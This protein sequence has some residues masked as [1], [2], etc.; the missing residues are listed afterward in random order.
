LRRLRNWLL[1]L[2]V[3]L[4]WSSN[5]PVMKS[6]LNYVDAFN[7]VLHRL[8]L[9][10]IALSPLLIYYR[11]RIPNSR[12]DLAKLFLLGV[13]ST[14]G[15]VATNT[16]LVY[17]GSGISAILTYTQPLFV[18]CIAAIFLKEEVKAIRLIGV[19]IGFTGVII[20]SI[21]GGQFVESFTYSTLLLII[22]AFL[23]A[24]S[25]VYYKR[26]LNHIDPIIANI[27]QLGVGA[28]LLALISL[29]SGLFNFPTSMEYIPLLLYAS[30]GATTI[31]LTIWMFLLREEEA[32]VLASS[33]FII[34]IV[35][36]IFGFILL[37]EIVGPTSL[38][39]AALTLTGVYL[40]NRT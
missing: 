26:F 17:E 3:V 19:L 35:A 20:L 28:L 22:G 14:V 18:F 8:A 13:I 5:W 40:V 1:F 4:I 36:L 9:S 7:F 21:K 29:P 25:I 31:A 37:G 27:A 33:S 2:V 32:V 23:W 39:G 6:G 34:P 11:T 38:L 10:T 24:L 16:G 15:I 12:R 30:I